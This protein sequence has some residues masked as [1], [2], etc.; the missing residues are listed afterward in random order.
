MTSTSRKRRWAVA[1]LTSGDAIQENIRLIEALIAEAAD[2]GCELVAFPENAT[3]MGREVD[4]PAI[5]EAIDGPT[6]TRLQEMAMKSGVHVLLGSFAER[7]QDPSRPYNSSVLLDS[8]GEIGAVY[9]K[10]H[11]FD[12]EVSG[13][14][15]Y[16]ES[17]VVMSPR[18]EVIVGDV[19][20]ARVG[21]SICFDLRFPWLYQ[22]LKSRGAVVLFVPAAFT[23]PTGRDHWDV[24]LRARAIETQAYVLAPAQA[25]QHPTG[26]CTYGR[27]VIVDPWGVVVARVNDGGQLAIAQL[28]LERVE[29]I[30]SEMPLV[31]REA[32]YKV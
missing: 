25:G 12:V 2:A 18:P 17:D 10:I 29:S 22:Q 7:S 26:R 21:L 6:V 16:R 27:S 4:K 23:V 20:G 8:R 15:T 30:R 3:F 14:R 31:S 5:A 1:Q 32:E 19:N 11:L 28:D 13:D 24:L 9:R